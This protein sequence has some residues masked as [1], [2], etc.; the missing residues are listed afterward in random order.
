MKGTPYLGANLGRAPP[1]RRAGAGAAGCRLRVGVGGGLVGGVVKRAAQVHFEL[2][3]DA[4]A[5]HERRARRDAQ[6][7]RDGVAEAPSQY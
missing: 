1:L 4:G 2:D 6:E 3:G 7:R 5:A